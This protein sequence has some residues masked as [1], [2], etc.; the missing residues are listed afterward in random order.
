[1]VASRCTLAR[2]EPF[3]GDRRTSLVRRL[4]SRMRCISPCRGP[5]KLATTSYPA[6]S[7][8][9]CSSH[10][11]GPSLVEWLGGTREQESSCSAAILEFPASAF[12]WNSRIA[13]E[14]DDSCSREIGRAHV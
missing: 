2:G 14:Q 12:G 4:R 1:M 8:N 10:C 11:L 5:A 9:L 13:A 3:F 6:A 7:T